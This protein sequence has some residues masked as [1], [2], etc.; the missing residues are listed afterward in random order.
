MKFPSAAALVL[1]T[2]AVNSETLAQDNVGYIDDRSD[3]DALVRSLP[4]V[5]NAP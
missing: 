2:L 1:S 3:G 5:C 4:T